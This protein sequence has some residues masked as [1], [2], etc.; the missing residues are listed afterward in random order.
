M[1]YALDRAEGEA[2]AALLATGLVPEHVVELT[3]PKANVPADLAFTTFRVAGEAGLA[4]PELARRIAAAARLEPGSLIGEVTAFGPFVNLSLAAGP[5]AAAVLA[6]VDRLG[7]RYGHDDRGGGRTV[8]VEYSSPNMARRMHVGHIRSTIIGQALFN[9]QAALGFRTISDNHIGDWGKNF[10]V[11]ITGIQHEGRPAGSGEAALA[12]LEQLYARYNTLIE[13]DPTIDQEARDWSLRLERGDPEARALWSWIVE[14]TLRINQP[15]Y[16]RLGVRFDTVHGE[17]FFE[18]RMAPII[19]EAVEQGVARPGEGGALVVDLADLPTFVL[20]RADGGTL[21]HTRDAATIV[22]REQTYHPAAIIYVVDVRQELYFR[23]LFAL[24]RALGHARDIDLIHVGFGTIVG[25]DGQPLAAR[26]GNMV[27]LQALLDQAH[28]R[29]RAVVEQASA[30]LPEAEKEAIAEAVGVGA[31]IYNDLYQ[32]P[33]RN[34][35]LDWERMLALNGN[36]APYIQYMHA[37]CRSILRRA[38]AAEPTGA[39]RP[40]GQPA[41]LTHPAEVTLVK[42][43]ARLPAAVREAGARQ[44]P[45]VVAEW[46]YQTARALAGFYRD[47]PVLQAETPA[48]RASRLRLVAA[49]AQALKNGLA[50]LG[51]A[52]PERM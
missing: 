28:D 3:R 18:D 16:D 52:A 40:P 34:I 25:P 20:R 19:A 10:G 13:Q 2:R 33:R 31:V 22:F 38:A 15:L 12:A 30:D 11:L 9:I 29:A 41:Q 5:L 49:T 1:D 32:D 14:L 8:L 24:V 47:C 37:R 36:S 45:F 23:Q 4:P 17:S 51:I 46:C 39:D 27:Y 21:Y 35:S 26:R 50:L 44:A 6:E 48:L 43:L 7:D 42:Q